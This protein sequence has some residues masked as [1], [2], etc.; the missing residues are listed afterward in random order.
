MRWRV[1]TWRSHVRCAP[2]RDAQLAE[3]NGS[4]LPEPRRLSAA[5]TGSALV[6]RSFGTTGSGDSVSAVGTDAMPRPVK[7]PSARAWDATIVQSIGRLIRA[8]NALSTLPLRSCSKRGAEAGESTR[9]QRP[10][11][12]PHSDAKIRSHSNTGT[13]DRNARARAI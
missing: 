2:R 4:Q 13:E 9:A 8:F 11:T 12:A 3:L 5:A 7:R 1:V 10:F 6:A